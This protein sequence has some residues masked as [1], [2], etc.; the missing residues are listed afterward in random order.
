MNHLRATSVL[1][2]AMAVLAVACKGSEA[3]AD[4]GADAGAV[5]SAAPRPKLVVAIVIDQFRADYLTRFEPW[6][7]ESGFKR[8]ARRGASWKG[9]Y[10]HYVTYTGPGHA[11]VLSGSYPYVNGIAANKFY[12]RET[13]RAEAMVFDGTSEILG[14]KKT[15]PDMDVSPRNFIGSTLGDELSLATSQRSRTIA[16]ATKGRGAIL[17]GGRL[18]KAYFM[19]DESGE[20]TTST[21]Y[22]SVLPNWV[23]GW[24]TK[25][26]PTPRS[27]RRG[28]A[29]SPSPPTQSRAPT[30]PRARATP[31]A[32]ARPS[33]TR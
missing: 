11:L 1:S 16:L 27:A 17:L 24:N 8:L 14:V 10:G 28:S 5:V 26:P 23:V 19:N 32:S 9:H 31:R 18:G 30:T 33:P 2:V 6:F 7:G 22:A 20:M 15:D 29:R 12:N 25:K 4:G 13:Q 3:P 21:Y